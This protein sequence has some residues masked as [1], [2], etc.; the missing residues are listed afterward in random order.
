MSS[1]KSLDMD[2]M[3]LIIPWHKLIAQAFKHKDLENI[4]SKDPHFEKETSSSSSFLNLERK[5]LGLFEN[6]TRKFNGP[7]SKIFF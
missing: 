2:Q 5:K 4:L 7:S 3:T 1:S 6:V